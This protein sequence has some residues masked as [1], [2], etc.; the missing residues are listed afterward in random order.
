MAKKQVLSDAQV[1]KAM[2][3]LKKKEA[4]KRKSEMRKLFN[5]VLGKNNPLSKAIRKKK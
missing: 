3:L 2:D 4:T 5:D 1:M